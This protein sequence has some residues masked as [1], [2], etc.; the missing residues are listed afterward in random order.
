V[1]RRTLIGTH[2]FIERNFESIVRPC[3]S[4]LW[5]LRRLKS[6]T[7]RTYHHPFM[8]KFSEE[9]GAQFWPSGSHRAYYSQPRDFEWPRLGVGGVVIGD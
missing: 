6:G 3:D 1:H 4:R 7:W 2:Q 9:E 8:I 5:R